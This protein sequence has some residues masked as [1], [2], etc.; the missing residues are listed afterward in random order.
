[1][2]SCVAQRSHLQNYLRIVSIYVIATS[3]SPLAL[4]PKND[5]HALDTAY[6]RDRVLA[7]RLFIIYTRPY[8][9]ILTAIAKKFAYSE[10]NR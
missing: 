1:M 5:Y 10:V 3:T 2:T 6:S 8:N 4:A 7:I 9:S